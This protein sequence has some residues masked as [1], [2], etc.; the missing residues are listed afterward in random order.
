MVQDI[1]SFGRYW[2][3][4]AV[5]YFSRASWAR[6]QMFGYLVAVAIFAFQVYSGELREAVQTLDDVEVLFRPY[7]IVFA[8][9]A[10]YHFATTAWRMDQQLRAKGFGIEAHVAPRFEGSKL[11]V[12]IKNYGEK[13][14]FTATFNSVLGVQNCERVRP[15]KY[16]FPWKAIDRE[17]VLL[18][19]GEYA[20]LEI[21]DFSQVIADD[22]A[23]PGEIKFTT[24]TDDVVVM[25][26]MIHA[27]HVYDSVRIDFTLSNDNDGHKT[28]IVWVQLVI[29]P[30][31]L[32][33]FV[34]G[35]NN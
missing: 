4:F 1:K 28:F 13:A 31:E 20:E 3:R 24:T 2:R 8:V 14:T 26:S 22:K 9:Y 5:L 25:P 12:G 10:A 18:M 7:A 15:G 27:G 11:L 34:F 23:L 17:R 21:G 19:S 16:R 30:S 32:T 29:G 35:W 33:R 6:E